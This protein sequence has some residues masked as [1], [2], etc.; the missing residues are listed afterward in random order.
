M[1]KIKDVFVSGTLEHL[2][3]Y[4]RMGTNCAR[5]KRFNIRQTEA[6]KARSFNFGIAS[7][8]GKGLRVGLSDVIPFPKDR[9]MQSRFSGAIAKWL[10]LS[11]VNELPSCD[12]AVYISD[13]AFTKGTTFRE[14][15]KAPIIISQPAD[16]LV[17]VTIGAFVPGASII[18]PAG[19]VSVNCTISVA[20][21]ML[22]SGTPMGRETHRFEIPFNNIE[23][24]AQTFDF[25]ITI[26]SGS[27][28]I[29]AAC[30]TYNILKNNRLTKTGKFG[31]V[32]AGILNARYRS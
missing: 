4:R 11:K 26:P 29:T 27:L 28:I 7:R 14:R 17:T 1:A 30:L 6:T 9:S 21:C 10:G 24:P 19:T 32:P 23:I 15:F 2:V 8:V 20:G 12:A 3:F 16:N 18:A 22:K 25:H 31:F 13:F 5:M